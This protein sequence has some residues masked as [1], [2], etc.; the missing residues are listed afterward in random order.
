MQVTVAL[1][2]YRHDGK[3]DAQ[4]VQERTQ[5]REDWQESDWEEKEA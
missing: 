3:E 2:Q 4:A 1:T 5:T